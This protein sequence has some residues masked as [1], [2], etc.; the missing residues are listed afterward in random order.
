MNIEQ[1]AEGAL[2]QMQAQGFQDVQVSVG[3]T[4]QDE[5]NIAQ[6]DASLFRSTE[7]H[8]MS[9]KGIVDGRAASTSLTDLSEDVIAHEIAGL[10]DRAQHSPQDDANAISSGQTAKVIK[11]PQE[12]DLELMVSKVQELLDYRKAET[13]KMAIDEGSASYHCSDSLL[14]TSQGTSLASTTGSYGL[15]A[16]GTA[17]EGDKS[18]SFAYAGGQTD[19][20][21]KAHAA[22]FFGIGDMLK[23]TERQIDTRSFGG[24]VTGD[25]VL[26]PMAVED[27]LQWFFGQLSD[28]QLISDSSVYRDKVGEVIASPL[29]TIKSQ[30]N[31]PLGDGITGDGF[32]AE[33]F[34]VV[35]KGKLLTLMPSLYGSRKTGIAHRPTAS[36]WEIVA[37]DTSKS[38][39]TQGIKKG[40]LV[41]RLSMGSPGPSGDF[42]GVI[43]NSFMIEDGA[44]SDALSETMIAGN[45]GQMLKDIVAV[46]SERLND[47][48]TEMPWIRFANV[49]Y[50]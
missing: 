42:S 28:G 40:A 13:P 39:L 16:M 2:K 1:I 11:G 36:G 26:A 14:L 35:E 29:L 46:S 21:K 31:G 7:D 45:M 12:A 32:V 34:T 48:S 41:T 49:N 43:K 22:E 47:G 20:L 38:D 37:G 6:S 27:L 8:G 19:D 44:V 33:D 25:V 9:L 23:E 15:V 3:V 24:N 30:F 4:R 50:S 17:R 5:L 18:S 10:F